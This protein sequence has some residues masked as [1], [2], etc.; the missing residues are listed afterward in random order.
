[1][2]RAIGAAESAVIGGTTSV[3][4]GGK[5]SNGAV[6]GAFGYL[7]NAAVAKPPAAAVNS[8]GGPYI[9]PS[10]GE[11]GTAATS[12]A[13]AAGLSLAL[14]EVAIAGEGMVTVTSWAGAGLTPDLA[15]GRWVM[16]GGPTLSN[17]VRTGLWGPQY[18][19]GVGFSL[20]IAPISNYISTQ[21]PA[22]TLRWPGGWE[23]IK[24]L[25]GQ[26]VIGN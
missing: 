11:V 17:Y 3:L 4:S 19:P 21:V 6:T 23:V 14:P 10:W 5:F 9:E 2:D 22:M 26:R 18:T 8:P 16:L 1:V 25:I 20:S 12:F 15:A 24:G 13:A 7:F